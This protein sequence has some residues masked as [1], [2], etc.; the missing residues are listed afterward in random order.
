MEREHRRVTLKTPIEAHGKTYEHLV[1]RKP[2]VKELR[3]TAGAIDDIDRSAR[4][5][6]ACAGVPVSSVDQMEIDDFTACNE[7]LQEMLPQQPA[8][9]Q[10]ESLS[11]SSQQT[12][13]GE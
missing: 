11:E 6:S 13:L 9:T 1:I 8:E 10:P 3:A 7:A 4:L 2:R 12:G 5:L